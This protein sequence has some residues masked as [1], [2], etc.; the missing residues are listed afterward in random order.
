MKT[1]RRR[2]FFTTVSGALPSCILVTLFK[3]I[4]VDAR[5]LYKLLGVTHGIRRTLDL[6][7]PLLLV[8][9]GLYLLHSLIKYA[10]QIFYKLMPFTQIFLGKFYSLLIGLNCFFVAFKVFHLNAHIMVRD[11]KYS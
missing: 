7:A 1:S 6:L 2:S 5:N 10:A 3:S 9:L 4:L 8:A 11:C